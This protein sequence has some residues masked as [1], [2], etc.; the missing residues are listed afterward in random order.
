VP[1]ARG[2]YPQAR[3][4]GNDF[5]LV[6]ALDHDQ[7]LAARGA[8]HETN[9]GAADA[10]LVGKQLEECLVCGTRDGGRRD[11]GAEDAVDDAVDLVRPGTR[12][13][14]NGKADVVISQDSAQPSMADGVPE[15]SSTVRV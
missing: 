15:M 4:S 11:P 14:T 12:R 7:F 13:Q 10:Q 9:G 8:C 2:S 6:H 3:P 5:V 1:S